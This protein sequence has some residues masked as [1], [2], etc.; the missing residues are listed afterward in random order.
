[1]DFVAK[2]QSSES[3]KEFQTEDRQQRML[4]VPPDQQCMAFAFDHA[5]GGA[6]VK[7]C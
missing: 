6:F 1:M 5:E 7:W 3:S 2:Q 4:G